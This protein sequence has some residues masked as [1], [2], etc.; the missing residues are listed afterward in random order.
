M[1]GGR[2]F[3]VVLETNQELHSSFYSNKIILRSFE[4]LLFLHALRFVKSLILSMEGKTAKYH[5][6]GK[7]SDLCAQLVSRSWSLLFEK[8]GL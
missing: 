1:N 5:K 8:P 2:Y 7:L 6:E 4:V 3:Q